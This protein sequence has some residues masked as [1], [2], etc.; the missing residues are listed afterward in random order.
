MLESGIEFSSDY[1]FFTYEDTALRCSA[2]NDKTFKMKNKV[3][4]ILRL[5]FSLSKRYILKH[6]QSIN[7]KKYD[8]KI[9]LAHSKNFLLNDFVA[10]YKLPFSTIRSV[11]VGTNLVSK[12]QENKY[13]QFETTFLV[14]HLID[15]TEV[16]IENNPKVTKIPESAKICFYAKKSGDKL[17]IHM[18]ILPKKASKPVVKLCNKHFATMPLPKIVTKIMVWAFPRFFLSILYHSEKNPSVSIFK[19]IIN[20]VA[21]YNISVKKIITIGV[22]VEHQR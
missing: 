8:T 17:I 7:G 4:R 18:R 15:N 21:F 10:R 5:N 20:P 11:E 14:V 22:S 6:V 13:Y 3:T 9:T 12:F 19:K 2:Q 16:K 1:S